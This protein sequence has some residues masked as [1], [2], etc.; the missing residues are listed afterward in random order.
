VPTA[1]FD[2]SRMI[3]A[4]EAG[5]AWLLAHVEHPAAA[6]GPVGGQRFTDAVG[7]AGLQAAAGGRPRAVVLVLGGGNQAADASQYTV[8]EVRGYLTALRVPLHVWTLERPAKPAKG[9]D[10]PAAAAVAAQALPA[11]PEA[12]D[13]SSLSKLR[14]AVEALKQDLASQV[15]VWVEGSHLPESIELA[16]AALQAGVRFAGRPSP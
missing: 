6:A 14:G 16:P 10:S 3:P 2:T 9:G 11:W 1:L 7:V 12:V 13:V 15:I 8:A 4:E 5:L